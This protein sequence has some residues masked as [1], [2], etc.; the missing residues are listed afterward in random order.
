LTRSVRTR[1]KTTHDAEMQAQIKR[2]ADEIEDLKQ[3]VMQ[4]KQELT[5]DIKVFE[6]QPDKVED[7]KVRRDHFLDVVELKRQVDDLE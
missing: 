5:Q 6:K 1:E 2:Q 4:S 3:K 7:V